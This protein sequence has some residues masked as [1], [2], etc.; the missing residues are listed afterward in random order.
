[1][2]FLVKLKCS[3]PLVSLNASGGKKTPWIHAVAMWLLPLPWPEDVPPTTCTLGRIALPAYLPSPRN[4]TEGS[5]AFKKRKVVPKTASCFPCENA[6]STATVS[7]R[8]VVHNPQAVDWYWSVGHLCVLSYLVRYLESKAARQQASKRH[9]WKQTS[10]ERRKGPAR[11]R[12]NQC[13]VCPTNNCF[14]TDDY[15]TSSPLCLTCV[16]QFSNEAMKP[17]NALID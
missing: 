10:L 14:W 16:D 13:W 5:Q 17:S 3:P 7:L 4:I 8:P 1:M 12:K 9:E 11:R 15:Y 6:V 2:L